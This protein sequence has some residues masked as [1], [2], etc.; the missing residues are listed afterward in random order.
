MPLYDAIDFFN[1]EYQQNLER[2]ENTLKR[3]ERHADA[4]WESVDAVDA[5]ES[6]NFQC[7]R[8]CL[9]SIVAIRNYLK[10][11]H[12][13]LEGMPILKPLQTLIAEAEEVMI[14][15]ALETMEHKQ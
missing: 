6:Q 3:A 15:H 4:L 9:E 8:D 5:L 1:E 12:H 7:D 2:N 14:C 10:H 13:R 11:H